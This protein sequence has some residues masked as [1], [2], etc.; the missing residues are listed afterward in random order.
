MS[1]GS[2]V[3]RKKKTVGVRFAWNGVRE[4]FKSERNF[5]IHLT[6]A[7]F[8]L[9]AAFVFQLSAVEWMI[10][11]TIISVILSLE[12]INSAIEKLLDYIH[13]DHH[14]LIGAI[15]D[16]T[17]GAVLVS[18]IGSVFIGFILFLPKILSLL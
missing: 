8:V 5:R 12:M 7:I 4:V 16:I 10:L 15:K 13:P 14:P 6:V 11:I 3:R 18:S 1:S 2:N 9:T 17:A